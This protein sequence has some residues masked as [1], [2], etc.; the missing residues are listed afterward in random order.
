MNVLRSFTLWL[1]TDCDDIS[2]GGEI[3]VD[4]KGLK[5]KEGLL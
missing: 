3:L 2:G 1:V 4:F 5:I